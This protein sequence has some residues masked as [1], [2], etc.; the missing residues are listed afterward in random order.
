MHIAFLQ[1][2]VPFTVFR[3]TITTNGYRR[4]ISRI[5]VV[6]KGDNCCLF[7]LG[8]TFRRDLVPEGKS[9]NQDSAHRLPDRHALAQN[10]DGDHYG[11]QRI[12]VTENGGL[13]SGQF[14]QGGEIQ[15]VGDTGV[16]QS[17]DQQIHP[18]GA[19]EIAQGDTAGE[20]HI[21]DQHQNGREKLQESPVDPFHIFDELV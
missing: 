7:A 17:H 5:R 1:S 10:G 14:F 13:L 16:D 11:Y 20:G 18:A 15:A 2:L 4:S 6:I 9:Q 12:D 19:A 8:F 21:G 3:N